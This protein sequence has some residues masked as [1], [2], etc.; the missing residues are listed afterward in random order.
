MI[1]REKVDSEN[2]FIILSYMVMDKDILSSAFNRYK[3]G[4]LKTKHFTKDFQKI[5]RWLIKYYSD[6]KKPPKRAIRKLYKKYRKSLSSENRNIIDG[7]LKR[8]SDEYFKCQDENIDLQFV[9]AEILPDFIREREIT[10]RLEKAQDKIYRGEFNEAEQ[11][12]STYSKV[13]VKEEEQNLGVIIPYIKK[14]VKHHLSKKII[15]KNIIYRFEGDLGNLIGPLQKSWLVAITGIE[16]VGKSY[17]LQDI[18]YNSVLYQSQKVLYINIELSDSLSRNRSWRRIS[19]TGNKKISKYVYPILDCENNQFGVCR[20]NKKQKNKI[21]LFR[22][23][24]EVIYFNNRED[25]KICQDCRFEKIRKNAVRMK[26]FIPSIWFD[27]INIK[28]ATRKRIMRSIDDNS[29]MRLTNYRIKCF[30]RYSVTFDEVYDFI[31]RYM[32]RFEWKPSIIIIDYLDI[33]A[34]ESG[35]ITKIDDI[36][37]KWKKASKLAGEL[38]CL[39]ITADQATKASRTQY[40]LDQMSTS[41]S[42]TKDAHLDVRIA[43]NKTDDEDE[44]GIARMGVL[45]HRHEDFS[46]KKE[47]LI[48]QRIETAQPILDNVKIFERGKKYR[49]SKSEF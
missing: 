41:E 38:N 40:A 37:T 48:T 46:I 25:W 11:I 24:D 31:L 47:V 36:D 30:P 49:V 35:A 8:I 17:I 45:F 10:E 6:Y 18:G 4:E 1:S 15:E 23:K 28:K 44:L 19:M 22:S 12:I 14:D 7:Y 5:F 26:R 9:K 43:L 32:E 2:E 13:N 29:M 20:V 42:K 39:V 16:K 3:S 21:P 27:K 34:K 33:L